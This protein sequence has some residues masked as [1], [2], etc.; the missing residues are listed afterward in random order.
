MKAPTDLKTEGRQ[1]WRQICADYDTRGN[2][3]VLHELCRTADRLAEIR[4][5]ITTAKDTT[6]FLKLTN[7][8]SK[9]AGTFARCWRLLGLQQAD[10]PVRGEHA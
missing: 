3:A 10:I 4:N 9:T 8:E 2:E 1:I 5:R 6:E 7:A